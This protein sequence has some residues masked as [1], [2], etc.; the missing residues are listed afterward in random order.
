MSKG[1]YAFGYLKGETGNH[2]LVRISPFDSAGR[3]HTSFAAVDVIPDLGESEVIE[4]DW[5]KD[6]REDTY[7][8]GGAG[9]QHVNKTDSAVRLT[10][11]P[12]GEVVQCQSERSQHKNR[13]AARKML[14]SKLYQIEQD[15]QAHANAARRGEKS[16][17]GFGGQNN[18]TLCLAAPAIR[19]GRSY[20][21][22]A[23]PIPLKF[24]TGTSIHSSKRINDGVSPNK[25]CPQ[26]NDRRC[27]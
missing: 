21:T 11:L 12:T 6:V 9:G 16:K 18:P 14:Q 17:I 13:A 25:T 1:D 5:D 4:I 10:H 7:R 23:N 26:Q 8:S 24:S 2:R 22:E 3:R 20:G 27:R 15:K 19:E